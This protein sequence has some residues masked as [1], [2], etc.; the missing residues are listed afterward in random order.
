[1]VYRVAS[2]LVQVHTLWYLNEINYIVG[3]II[4]TFECQA[5]KV[6]GTRMDY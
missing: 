3:H 4:S 2:Y 5:G 1:V 6:K